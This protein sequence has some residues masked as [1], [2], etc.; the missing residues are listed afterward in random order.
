[1]LQVLDYIGDSLKYIPHD[2]RKEITLGEFMKRHQFLNSGDSL[3]NMANA[4]LRNRI[5]STLGEMSEQGPITDW[6]YAGFATNPMSL[7]A[8]SQ[9]IMNAFEKGTSYDENKHIEE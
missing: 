6:E 5:E 3:S 1:M 2:R 4:I 9:Q 8:R 7:E